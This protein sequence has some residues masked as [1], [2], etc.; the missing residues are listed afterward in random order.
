MSKFFTYLDDFN[1]ITIIVPESYRAKDIPGFKVV[2]NDEEIELEIEKIEIIGF[3]KKYTAH[4]D[5][6]IL[7]NQM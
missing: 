7:L 2:G 6:Y 1:K 3:E 4:F 5:G